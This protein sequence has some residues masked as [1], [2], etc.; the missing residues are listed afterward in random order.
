[1]SSSRKN[2]YESLGD[3]QA[4]D[5]AKS[6]R[7]YEIK[8]LKALLASKKGATEAARD[9]DRTE[10]GLMWFN[11]EMSFPLVLSARKATTPLEDLVARPSKTAALD[12]YRELFEE[13]SEVTGFV[14]LV[15]PVPHHSNYI[16]H[17]SIALEAEPGYVRLVMQSK[18]LGKGVTIQPFKRFCVE[19]EPHW[20]V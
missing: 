17:N 11:R 20:S 2:L 1:M 16:I 14:G 4:A 6:V 5:T 13:S 18:A 7:R 12:A 8:I 19:V 10:F 15:F 9:V 3:S